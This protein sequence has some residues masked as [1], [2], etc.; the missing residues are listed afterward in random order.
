MTR[1]PPRRVPLDEC[2]RARVFQQ[3]LAYSV[4]YVLFSTSAI[5]NSITLMICRQGP[6]VTTVTAFPQLECDSK[7]WWTMIPFAIAASTVYIL[8]HMIFLGHA[9]RSI[10][11]SRKLSEGASRGSLGF[12]TKHY[13]EHEL[14]MNLWGLESTSIS[15]HVLINCSLYLVKSFANHYMN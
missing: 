3:G 15:R 10:A 13:H 9:V 7:R 2:D 8:L 4:S 1:R 5:S 14:S 12:V 6:K 11:M